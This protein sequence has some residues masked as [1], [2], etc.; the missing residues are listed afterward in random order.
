[1]KLSTLVFLSALVPSA[2]AAALPLHQDDFAR[3]RAEA[4][5]RHLP[6]FVDVWAPW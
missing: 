5:E 1:M 2:A 3:A 6:L 4:K